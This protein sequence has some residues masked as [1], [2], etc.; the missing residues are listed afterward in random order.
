MSGTTVTNPQGG[1]AG[2]ASSSTAPNALTALSS[3]YT[4][5]LN[6]LMTQLKNQDP[7][8][9]MDPNQFTSELVQFSGVEQQI[10]TNS[11]LTSLIQIAQGSQVLQSSTIVGK[12]VDVTSSKLSLQN[13]TAAIN[14][15]PPAAG[16]V[17]IDVLDSNG[18]AIRQD[19]VNATAGVNSWTWNGTDAT[20][21]TRPD[22]AYT[23]VVTGSGGGAGTSAIPFSVVGTATGIQKSGTALQLELGKLQVDFSAIQSVGS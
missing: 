21:A 19:T 17:T 8:A 10:N 13:G 9:P 20:G 3:N 4:N 1:T 12:T 2:S 22:G 18:N 11:N 16:P 7:S 6:L 23:V 15:T 14:F 5:F